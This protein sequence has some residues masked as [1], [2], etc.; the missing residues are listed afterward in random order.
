MIGAR[1]R[2]P[3]Q[4]CAKAGAFQCL[5]YRPDTISGLVHFDQDQL[6]QP[7]A[8]IRECGGVWNMRRGQQDHGFAG[9]CEA[10]QRRREQTQLTYAGLRH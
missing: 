4:Q 10:S 1:L 7:Y 6:L 8:Q 5:F 9:L 2:Q 3:A